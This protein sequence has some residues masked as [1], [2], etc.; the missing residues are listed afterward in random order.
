MVVFNKQQKYSP[1]LCLFYLSLFNFKLFQ[2]LV[3]EAGL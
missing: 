1:Q 3:D 2:I